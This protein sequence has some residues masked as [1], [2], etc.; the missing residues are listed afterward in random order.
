M[1]QIERLYREYSRD[2][3]QYLLSLTH[4]PSL[5]DDLMSETFLSAIRSIHRYQGR[6]SLKTW[7]C[8]IARHKWLDHLKGNRPTLE[9]HELLELYVLGP[10]IEGQYM[11]KELIERAMELLHEKDNKT[12]RIVDMRIEGYSYAEIA[13]QTGLSENSARVIDFRVKKWL[14][15][16]LGKEE[17][18]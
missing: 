2:V 16:T 18:L 15:E 6:A 5:A 11:I 13:E 7:L 10:G 8:S 9:Y 17:W 3:Y 4:H 14:K 12:R 1:K